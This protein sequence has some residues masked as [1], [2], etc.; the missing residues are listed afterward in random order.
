MFSLMRV[1][2]ID[3]TADPEVWNVV[4]VGS[5]GAFLDQHPQIDDTFGDTWRPG[6]PFIIADT[7]F[8]VKD[9]DD[10]PFIPDPRYGYMPD[11]WILDC[12]LHRQIANEVTMVRIPRADDN[13]PSFVPTQRPANIREA[14]PDE[15]YASQHH[16]NGYWQRVWQRV[17]PGRALV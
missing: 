9:G 2:K 16:D 11:G 7:V 6:E 10:W 15:Y 5:V 14:T 3:R 4:W 17:W 13:R 12:E 8:Q 1:I